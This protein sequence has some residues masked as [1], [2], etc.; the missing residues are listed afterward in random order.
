M[1]EIGWNGRWHPLA[2]RFPMLDEDG[3]WDMANSLREHGQFVPCRLNPDGLG[4]DGRNRVAACQIAGIEPRWE[5]YDGDPVAFIVEINAERRHLTTGQRAMAVAIGLDEAGLRVNGR[6]KRGSVPPDNSGSTVTGWAQAVQHAGFVLDHEREFVDAVLHGVM[7]LDNAY[8]TARIHRDTKARLAKLDGALVALVEAGT[9][10]VPEAEARAEYQLRLAA[11]PDDLGERVAAE[12]LDLN[13]A[14][15]IVRER[16]E[17]A[18]AWAS[19]IRNAMR[20]LARM[21]DTEIPADLPLTHQERTSLVNI[22]ASVKGGE[23]DIWL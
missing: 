1:S 19:K 12:H 7:T 14:E 16:R 3:L 4:L 9:L 18:E 11:L 21:S 5:I 2:E 20:V 22:L 15:L 23:H 8:S 6:F 17:R 13:E 10:T